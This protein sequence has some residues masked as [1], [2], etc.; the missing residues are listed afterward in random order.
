VQERR[1]LALIVVKL[2]RGV[3]IELMKQLHDVG[4]RIRAAES[5]P[6]TVKAK[7][8]ISRGISRGRVRDV[9]KV[10]RWLGA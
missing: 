8:E 5:V 3:S 7:N 6:G 4:V 1:E 10:G 9:K 2:V